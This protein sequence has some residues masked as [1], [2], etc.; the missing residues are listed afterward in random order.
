MKNKRKASA[1]IVRHVR[2]TLQWVIVTSPYRRY[3]SLA[4]REEALSSPV[5]QAV[6]DRAMP[7]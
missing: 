5:A 2:R 4:P 1:P 7:T 6:I 3:I